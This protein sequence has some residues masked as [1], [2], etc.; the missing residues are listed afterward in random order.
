MPE[1]PEVEFGRKTA[2]K[3]A[4][5]RRIDRVWCDDDRIVYKNIIPATMARKLRGRVVH[6]VCR[7]GKYLWFDLDQGASPVFHFGMTGGFHLPGEKSIQLESEPPS[8]DSTWPPRFAKI[9]LFFDD[10][11]ELVMTNKR[12]FGR[13][14]LINDP[15]QEPPISRLGFDPLTECPS[16]K[17]FK[18][19][20]R[21]RKGTIKGILL[22]QSFAAGIGNWIADEI[23]FQA[24]LHPMTRA[25]AL[26]DVQKKTLFAKMKNVI[27]RAVEVD[28]DKSRFPKSWLF[29]HRWGKDTN[30]TLADGKE[31]VHCTVAGRTTAFVP[32]VQ[33]RKPGS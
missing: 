10:G 19:R 15:L 24:K 3:V 32:A 11:G 33:G 29:H 27:K 20:L 18:E 4:L 9:H 14:W 1:L 25:P 17:D 13:I 26:S 22:D 7:K 30:A 31:I 16:L 5:N 2:E 21:N 12:R 28:A 6:Q 23:L 8:G